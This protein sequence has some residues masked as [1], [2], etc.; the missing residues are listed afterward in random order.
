MNT[1]QY[2][3][4][5]ED[6]TR[7]AS[8]Y[9]HCALTAHADGNDPHARF[10]LDDAKQAILNAQEL[11][12]RDRGAIARC[13]RVARGEVIADRYIEDTATLVD[14]FRY[15]LCEI[16]HGDLHEHTIAPD[17]MGNPHAY[18]MRDEDEEN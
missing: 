3:N 4:T 17:V 2:G 9:L 14:S 6:L 12:R 5:A 7:I 16:C 10:C 1:D 11:R 13:G 8:H 15:T 18:C